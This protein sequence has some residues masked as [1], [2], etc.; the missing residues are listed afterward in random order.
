MS[1]NFA[2]I[3]DSYRHRGQDASQRPA[4]AHRIHYVSSRKSVLPRF[5]KDTLQDVRRRPQNFLPS[6]LLRPKSSRHRRAGIAPS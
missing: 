1:V 6:V 4:P 3:G 5:Y 2:E